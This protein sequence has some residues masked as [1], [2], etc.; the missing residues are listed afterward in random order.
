VLIKLQII[1]GSTAMKKKRVTGGLF[2]QLSLCIF[3]TSLQMA[4]AASSPISST[5]L[6]SRVEGI[7][8]FD[9]AWNHWIAIQN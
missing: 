1:F 6:P 9:K 8:N 3:L 5:S 7:T 4:F 2:S